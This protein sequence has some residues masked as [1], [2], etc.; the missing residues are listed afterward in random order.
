[1]E[2]NKVI[3][4][5]EGV[6]GVTCAVLLKILGFEVEIISKKSPLIFDN[7]PSFVSQFPSASVIPHSINHPGLRDIFQHSQ[8]CFSILFENSFPG[9][10]KNRHFEIFT[11]EQPLPFYAELMENFRVNES[12]RT[13]SHPKIH[14]PFNWSFDCFF[15]DWPEYFPHLITVFESLGGKFS[16]IDLRPED[17]S[18]LDADII[19][20]CAELGAPALLGRSLDPVLQ[21]GHLLFVK[22]APML[23]T[24]NGFPVSYNFTPGVEHYRSESG[25]PQDVYCYPRN[26]GWILGGSRQQGTLDKDKNWIGEEVIEPYSKLNGEKYPEQI[27]RLNME[28]IENSFGFSTHQF[29]DLQLREGYRFM[30]N[31][32]PELRIDTTEKDHKLIINNYGHGGSGVTLSWGCA[33]KVADLLSSHVQPLNSE[34]ERLFSEMERLFI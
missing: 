7:D 16:I 31:S 15:A 34:P 19:I 24:P 32:T 10:R 25:N 9:L 30:G 5:G 27:L 33:F 13:P 23:R 18:S 4:I 8:E 26:D 22:G 14:S 1:M 11:E 29:T 6:S 2:S 17:L 3:V 28:I 12:D 21:R 20:N